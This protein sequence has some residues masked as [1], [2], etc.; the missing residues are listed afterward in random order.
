MGRAMQIAAVKELCECD[1]AF[2]SPEDV[3]DITEPFEFEGTTYT[4]Y[5]NPEDPKGLTFSDGAT[6]GEGCD[7]A[8]L[9]FEIARHLGLNRPTYIRGRGS[10]LRECCRV[11]LEHLEK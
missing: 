6:K 2:L 10:R 1:H 11:I 5:A 3:K 9:A 8:E 7:A 4:A